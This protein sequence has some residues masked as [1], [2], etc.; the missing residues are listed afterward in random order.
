MTVRADSRGAARALCS[1]FDRTLAPKAPA[2][3]GHK[4]GLCA[5]GMEYISPANLRGGLKLP[6]KLAEVYRS[7]D[8]S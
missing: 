5:P 6:L 1:K 2:L 8:I 7:A 3:P 4:R